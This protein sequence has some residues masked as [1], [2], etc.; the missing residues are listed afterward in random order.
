MQFTVYLL[1][2]FDDYKEFETCPNLRS[3]LGVCLGVEG[4]GGSGRRPSFMRGGGR[5]ESL[6][7]FAQS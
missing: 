1:P 7:S 4:G 5:L 6:F 2:P 3:Q